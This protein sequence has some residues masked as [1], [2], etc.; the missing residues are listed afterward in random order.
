MVQCRQHLGPAAGGFGGADFGR[1][2]SGALRG[3]V[4]L[5]ARGPSKVQMCQAVVG[6]GRARRR[7]MSERARFRNFLIIVMSNVFIIRLAPH[8]LHSLKSHLSYAT[9][10]KE[11]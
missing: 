5:C 9:I 3:P 11:L 2:L 1:R 8:R 4:S 7:F 10:L 6:S